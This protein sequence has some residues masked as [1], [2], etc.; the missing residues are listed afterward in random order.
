MKIVLAAVLM[1]SMSTVLW[2][3][4]EVPDAPCIGQTVTGTDT[5]CESANCPNDNSCTTYTFTAACTGTYYF[6]AWTTCTH[7]GCYECR[8]CATVYK[9]SGDYIGNCHSL[10]CSLPAKQCYYTCTVQ[11]EQG[12]QYNLVVCLEHCPDSDCDQCGA[13]CTAHG[14]LRTRTSPSCF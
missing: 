5:G 3:Q 2:A 6:D 11:L 4:G 9:V 13:D 10:N 7:G 14:C 12:T 1:L 8:S